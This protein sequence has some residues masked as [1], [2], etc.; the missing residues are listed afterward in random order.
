MYL[1]TLTISAGSKVIR[2]ITFRKGI[3]LI[4]DSSEGQITGNS[5][6]KTTVLKLIDFCFGAS[7]KNIWEDPESKKEVYKLVK[8]HLESNEIIVFLCLTDNLDNPDAREITIERNFLSRNKIIRRIN[9]EDVIE[10]EFEPKLTELIFP[11][12][13]AEKPSFRQIISHNI[14]YKDLSINNTLRTLDRYTSDAEYETLHLFLLGIEFDNGNRKQELLQKIKQ[15]TTF[16]GRLEKLQTRSAFEAAISLIEE[17][18]KQLDIKKSNLNLNENL[19]AELNELNGVKYQITRVASEINRLNIRREIIIENQ[20]QLSKDQFNV[21]VDQLELIYEQA[22]NKIG[23]IQK[24]FEELVEYHNKMIKEKVRFITNE[25]PELKSSLSSYE[26]QLSSLRLKE[27]EL[28]NSISKSGSFEE[29]ELLIS[30]LN[31]KHN[32]RGRYQNTITQLLEV[33]EN[34]KKFSEELNDID[35]ELF[36]DDFENSL[37]VQLNKFNIHFST[38]SDFLYDE[39]YALKYDIIRNRRGQKLCKFSAFNTN[40]SSGK[41]Q[42]EISCFDIAYTVFADEENIPCLHF[43]LNDKKELMHDNQLMKIAELV[44]KLDIQ[45]VASILKDKLPDELNNPEY[46]IVE[47]S[48]EDKLFRIEGK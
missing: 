21:D 39:K 32:K 40:F 31:E 5:V 44:N 25:L 28:T 36:S 19:E 2:E 13:T 38:I 8:D 14:R 7:K 46:F 48:E 41:K 15:E 4:V 47:L 43:L 35:E 12:H 1:K 42:G 11:D 24:T 3:N 20:N 23:S 29:L 22:T 37:K 34:I 10:D 33:E 45:F 18:I 27:R 16:K 9:D 17:E 6:G 26:S 30:E